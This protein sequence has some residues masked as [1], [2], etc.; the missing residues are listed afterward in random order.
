MRRK[1]KNR[2]R[3]NPV[4]KISGSS[5]LNAKSSRIFC[6]STFKIVPEFI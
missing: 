1:K 5:G 6:R 3:N 2:I 4:V